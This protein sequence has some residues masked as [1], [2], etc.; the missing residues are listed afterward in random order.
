MVRPDRTRTTATRS[1][2]SDR[3]DTFLGDRVPP[4]AEFFIDWETREVAFEDGERVTLRRPKVRWGKMWFGPIGEDTLTSLRLAQPIHG[5]GLLEAVP[6]E[7]ILAI[8]KRQRALGFNGRPNYVR[9]DIRKRETLGRFG[10]KANQP[11]LAQQ[12]AAAY[13]ADLGVTSS[14]Y[15]EMNCPPVQTACAGQAPGNQPELIDPDWEEVIFWEQTLAVPA[16]RDTGAPEFKRGAALFREAR[17][18]ICHVPELRTAQEVPHLKVAANQLIR[19]YTDLLLHDMGEELAD[20]RPEFK[21][22][23]RDW[24][25]QPLWGLGLSQ[26]VSGSTAMLHDGRA[27]NA[28]EA[29]LWHGGEAQASRDTFRRMKREDRQALLKYLDSI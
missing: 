4:E 22:G 14:L 6:E 3:D 16:R 10:W 1:R 24:R 23:G 11:S 25:T 18:D 2:T 27:R 9:D 8:A 29:I 20:H 13:A 28:T 21:A 17:C 7:D 5:L 19:P 12:I 15:P 26:V